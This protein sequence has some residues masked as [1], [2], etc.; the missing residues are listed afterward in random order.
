ML[1]HAQKVLIFQSIQTA[2]TVGGHNYTAIKTYRDEW[3]G[4]LDTPIISLQYQSRTR[5][6]QTTIGQKAEWD[7]DALS[8]DVYA[9]TDATN[10]V[11]G[12]KIVEE[13]TRTLELWFRLNSREALKTVRVVVEKVSSIKDLSHLEEGIFRLRFEVSLLYALI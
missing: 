3:R 5:E 1:S 10:G 4:V 7:T 11:H 8:I 9:K 6:K 12:M 2:Y 13:I